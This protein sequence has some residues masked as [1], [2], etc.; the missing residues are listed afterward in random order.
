MHVKELGYVG[1]ECIQ[2]A[3][4]RDPWRAVVN[5]M[6]NLGVEVSLHLT[7]RQLVI[8]SRRFEATWCPHLQELLGHLEH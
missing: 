2:L 1:V 5:M 6:L 8:G 3:Q 7:L 4:G